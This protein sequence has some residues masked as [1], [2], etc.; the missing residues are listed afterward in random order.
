MIKHSDEFEQVAVRIALT[1]G[2]PHEQVGTIG[3]W[4]V[5]TG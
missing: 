1:S 5:D 2:L 4:E 3:G